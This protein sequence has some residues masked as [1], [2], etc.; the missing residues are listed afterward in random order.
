MAS[1]TFDFPI[2][3][4]KVFPGHLS[5]AL[6]NVLLNAWTSEQPAMAG[7]LAWSATLK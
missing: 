3:Q 2:R 6:N 7:A 1:V 4:R 5:W